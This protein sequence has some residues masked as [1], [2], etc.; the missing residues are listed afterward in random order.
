MNGEAMLAE[1]LTAGIVTEAD[2][3]ETLRLTTAFEERFEAER[4]AVSMLGDGR[5]ADTLVGMLDETVAESLAAAAEEGSDV[6]ATACAVAA[7]DPDASSDELARI[8]VTVDQ[9][10]RGFAPSDG[11]PPH[12]TP[13]HGDH[14]GLL[15]PAAGRSVVFVWRNHCSPCESMRTEFAQLF[16]DPPED[17]NLF[18]VYGPES[19]ALLQREYDVV[20]GPTT[21]FTLGGR[22]DSRLQGAHHRETIEN[23]LAALRAQS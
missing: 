18:A 7:F 5:L 4:R 12:F 16:P 9:L 23:E 8:V 2:D 3:G 14:L 1:L 6:A 21:L 11:C 15:L 13:V 17:L 19:A 22:V 10:R 20:G